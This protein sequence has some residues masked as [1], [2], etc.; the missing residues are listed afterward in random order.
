MQSKCREDSDLDCHLGL[1]TG[2]NRQEVPENQQR[3]L[4]DPTG[5]EYHVLREDAN[6]TCTYRFKRARVRDGSQQ[7]DNFIRLTL[8]Q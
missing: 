2:G 6:Y 1:C 8:G 4:Y 7:P 3:S 5:F